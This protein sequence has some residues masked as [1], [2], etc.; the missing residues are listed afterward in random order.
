MRGNEGECVDR[1]AAAAEHVDRTPA[2]GLDHGAH[3]SGVHL[4]CHLERGIRSLAA[5]DATR[6]V[7]HDRVIGEMGRQRREAGRTHR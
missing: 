2:K 5:L 3:V 6:V 1:A 7:R 4:R